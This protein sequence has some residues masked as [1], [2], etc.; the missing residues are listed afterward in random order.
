MKRNFK[1]AI[2][3]CSSEPKWEFCHWLQAGQGHLMH[4]R[5]CTREYLHSKQHT[6][7]AAQGRKV[8]VSYKTITSNY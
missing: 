7:N 6:S 4:A 1:T 8:R 2:D 5:T 3:P